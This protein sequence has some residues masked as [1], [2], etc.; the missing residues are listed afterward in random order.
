LLGLDASKLTFNK[1]TLRLQKCKTLPGGKAAA[2]KAM[3]SITPKEGRSQQKQVRDAAPTIS[4]PKGDPALG[5]R[6]RSLSKEE[7]KAAKAGNADRIARRLAKKKLRNTVKLDD[8]KPSKKRTTSSVST[9]RKV[10][11]SGP[12]G[13]G[14]VVKRGTGTRPKKS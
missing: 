8:Q 11:S 14:K 3:A 5:D 9:E 12:R 4:L 10:H 2:P 7:R 13:P 1:R 6:I